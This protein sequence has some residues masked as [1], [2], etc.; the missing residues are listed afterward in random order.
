MYF[1]V[2][3]IL[4]SIISP[5]F[6]HISNDFVT[7]R[8]KAESHWTASEEVSRSVRVIFIYLEA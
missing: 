2:F 5:L 1:N 7:K 4:Y 8:G 6:T 3:L